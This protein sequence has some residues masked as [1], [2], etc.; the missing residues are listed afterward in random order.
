MVESV[1]DEGFKN[2]HHKKNSIAMRQDMK[3]GQSNVR[4][5]MQPKLWINKGDGENYVVGKL[6]HMSKIRLHVD[7]ENIMMQE[8]IVDNH[9][10]TQAK[11]MT[12]FHKPFLSTTSFEGALATRLQTPMLTPSDID[13]IKGSTT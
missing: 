2:V 13:P 11:V 10:Y 8:T 7:D 9:Q 1:D 5:P 4:H 12:S 6:Q 3:I